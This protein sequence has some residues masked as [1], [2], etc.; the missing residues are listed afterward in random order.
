MTV[1]NRTSTP[2][3]TAPPSAYVIAAPCTFFLTRIIVLH[4]Q[5]HIRPPT[6]ASHRCRARTSSTPKP[7]PPENDIPDSCQPKVPPLLLHS[8]H[9]LHAPCPPNMVT[10]VAS[11]QLGS[12]SKERALHYA[13][14]A[15]HS[16]HST[17]RAPSAHRRSWCF[18][19]RQVRRHR[20]GGHKE[21]RNDLVVYQCRA[22]NLHPRSIGPVVGWVASIIR[23]PDLSWSPEF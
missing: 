14:H 12:K 8:T 5:A 16:S 7:N 10:A 20:L 18:L 3:F 21:S 11:K 6:N 15:A 2:P 17:T 4:L 22:H 13:G 19:F 1:G 23:P 9:R